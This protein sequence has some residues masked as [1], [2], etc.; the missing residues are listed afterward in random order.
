MFAAMSAATVFAQSVPSVSQVLMWSTLTDRPVVASGGFTPSATGTVPQALFSVYTS[1]TGN[2]GGDS[3]AFVNAINN[4]T[5]YRVAHSSA[6]SSALGANMALTLSTIPLSSP[7]S[8]RILK[9]DPATGAQLP[10]SSSLGPILTQ[11]AETVGKGKLFLGFTH[12]NYHFK[13]FNGE[14]LNG[15]TLMY[16][17]NDPSGI[18]L[19]SAPTTTAPATYNLGLDVR[20]SQDIAF[21]TYGLTDRFDISAGFPM[22]HAAV[23]SRAYNGVVY[24]GTGTS[25]DNG[26]R[27]WCV[28]TLSPGSFQLTTMDIGQSSKSK[29]GFGDL[30]LRFKGG[31][32]E[33]PRASLA[34]GVDVR[35]PTGDEEN[36]LGAGTTNLK[37]FFALSL[38][39]EPLANGIVI[40][41]H[42]EGGWQFGGK[43]ILGG[44]LQGTP[45]TAT[46]SGGARVPVIGGPFVASKD[47]LPDV[48][49]WGAGAEVAFGSR[50]TAVFDVLGNQIGMVRGAQLLSLRQ[51]ADPAPTVLNGATPKTA[52]MADA[53]K[54]SFGQYSA[55]I[56]YKARI[57]GGLVATF[58]V[59]IRLNDSGLT[60]RAVPL[61]GLG[62]GF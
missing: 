32:F 15:L 29:T 34:A 62:Y 11:R 45:G 50:N 17:G 42:V 40:A 6:L 27:C 4:P 46:L 41:P 39:S 37:P 56:G 8:G 25:F 16:G 59:L 48:L 55:A 61:F 47:Y 2:A 5:N 58:Q 10:V 12:Q 14:K 51:I 18:T 52:G 20:L 57:A 7:T 38:Y 35:L 43:S 1:S 49:S 24:S 21:L 19:G 30:L 13:E 3:T 53:G 44:T 28:N 36:Y 54:G 26:S 23:S 31:V 9:T 22:V 60:A 33:T